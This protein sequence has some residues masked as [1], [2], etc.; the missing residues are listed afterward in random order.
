[1]PNLAMYSNSHSKNFYLNAINLS[2]NNVVTTLSMKG[3]NT[4]SENQNR[5]MQFGVEDPLGSDQE[6]VLIIRP[7]LTL[8]TQDCKTVRK[9]L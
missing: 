7:N 5:K 4:E 1:M 2:G 8:T 6:H 3:T 9:G